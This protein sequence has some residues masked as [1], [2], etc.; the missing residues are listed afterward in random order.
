MPASDTPFVAGSNMCDLEKSS[1]FSMEWRGT[2]R[3]NERGWLM[4]YEIK[5]HKTQRLYLD[6]AISRMADGSV[7]FLLCIRT[8]E[9]LLMECLDVARILN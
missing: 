5:N 7:F 1:T 9:V 4:T 2:T 6:A 8:L 3:A